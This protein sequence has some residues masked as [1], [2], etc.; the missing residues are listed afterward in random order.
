[1]RFLQILAISVIA[2][3]AYINIGNTATN[4]LPS[5]TNLQADAK[6]ALKKQL[7]IMVVFTAENCPYCSALE[8]DQLRPMMISGDYDDKVILR[9][10]QIDTFDDITFFN[11]KA[12]P[13]ETLAQKYNVWVTPTIMFFDHQGHTLAPK[14]VGYN[15]PDMF[16]GYLDQSID[17]SRQMIR[18]ELASNARAK[19]TI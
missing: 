14:I 1:M 7:P 6:L 10:L 13:A 18:R 9:T 4:D 17:E 2:L 11:G 19:P 3:L 16:G 5:T 12:I 15:T 8:S